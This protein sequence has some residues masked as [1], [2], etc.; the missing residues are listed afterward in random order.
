VRELERRV[1]ENPAVAGVTLTERMPVKSHATSF[2]EIEGESAGSAG[3]A[4]SVPSDSLRPQHE[5][6]SGA[7]DVDFLEVFHSPVL[8]GR[9]FDGRDFSPGSRTVIVT[10]SFV[11]EVFGGR[12]AIGKRIR[13]ATRDGSA[14]PG[15]W[16]EIVGVVRDLVSDRTRSLDLEAR[17]QA[18]IYHALDPLSGGTY[19]VHLVAHVR[20]NPGELVP[21]LHRMAEAISPELRIH[22]PLTLDRAN[23]DLAVLWGLYARIIT[24]VSGIAL[25]LS[26]AGIYAVMSFTVARRTREIGVRVA[27]GA[28]PMRVVIEVFRSPFAQVGLGVGIGCV[29]VG[30]VVWMMTSGRA[31]WSDAL[32]LLACIAPTLRALRIEPARALGSEG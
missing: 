9:A 7:I 28:R 14:E 19:P 6:Y 15:P 30:G 2:V 24:G 31:T 23:S 8:A 17:P 29:L 16:Y 32:L 18:R 13:H 26:L 11:D 3:S 5:V 12:G 20:G 27:L 4:A 1:A 25:F 10:S 22:D 21:A